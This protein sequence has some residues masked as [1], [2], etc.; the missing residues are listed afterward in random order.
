[1]VFKHI[2]GWWLN[3]LRGEP[4]AVFNSS[5][6]KEVFP[7]IQPKQCSA[8]PSFNKCLLLKP[9]CSTPK[10]P[11]VSQRKGSNNRVML[12]MPPA[13][14]CSPAIQGTAC[15][16]RLHP[17]CAAAVQELWEIQL[18]IGCNMLYCLLTC[19]H[20]MQFQ[21]FYTEVI[22]FCGKRSKYLLC[23]ASWIKGKLYIAQTFERR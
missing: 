1:M 8:F 6:C 12:L 5:F 7:D 18:L 13:P 2:Q 10:G 22:C 19:L 21:L 9:P 15:S 16:L 3:H 11:P 17:C 20:R 23:C 4:I 14:R